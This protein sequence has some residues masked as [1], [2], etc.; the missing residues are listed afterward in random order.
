MKSHAKYQMFNNLNDTLCCLH[1]LCPC[2]GLCTLLLYL[3]LQSFQ[4]NAGNIAA[5]AFI[6]LV[7]TRVNKTSQTAAWSWLGSSHVSFALCLTVLYTRNAP[8]CP[9]TF[10][11][12]RVSKAGES[13]EEGKRKI[14]FFQTSHLTLVLRRI[15]RYQFVGSCLC[16]DV[17]APIQFN[18]LS[19]HLQNTSYY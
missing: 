19:L 3:I 11:G 2:R 16:F 15:S 17:H 8:F 4:C 5:H 9:C 13:A 7:Y 1:L 18:H 14:N 6:H 12:F 10:Y